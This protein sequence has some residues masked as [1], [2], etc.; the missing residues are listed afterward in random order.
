[1]K[2]QSTVYQQPDTAAIDSAND[3][4]I[5][6]TN[7]PFAY[8]EFEAAKVQAHDRML[9]NLIRLAAWEKL[10]Y[11]P[12]TM[13]S[14]ENIH[15]MP[16]WSSK[17]IAIWKLLGDKLDLFAPIEVADIELGSISQ[18]LAIWEKEGIEPKA[19]ARFKL[20]LNNSLTNEAMAICYRNQWNERLA[21][22]IGNTGFWQGLQHQDE[23][24]QNPALFFEQWGA[25]GHPFHPTTKAKLGI[26]S[27]QVFASSPEFKGSARLTL[28]AIKRSHATLSG[29]NEHEYLAMFSQYFPQNYI[30][31]Q[32]T[33]GALS[34]AYLPFPVHPQQLQA[35]WSQDL[36][37]GLFVP[38][39]PASIDSFSSLSFRTVYPVGGASK[40]F[41]KLPV[42]LQ[43]TSVQRTVSPR[44][45]YMGPRMSEL[46]TEIVKRDTLIAQVFS[47]LNE[48]IGLHLNTQSEIAKHYSVIFRA[49]LSEVLKP[50]EVA[51]PVA[52]LM[53]KTP[54]NKC[55]A[56]HVLTQD[57]LTIEA[58]LPNFRQYVA[59]LLNGVLAVYLKYGIALEAHQQNSFM[60]VADNKPA[61]FI[62][63]DFGGVRVHMESLQEKG[64]NLQLHQDRLIVE[65]L[66][67]KCLHKLIHSLFVCHLGTLVSALASD[68]SSPSKWFWQIVANESENVFE[69]CKLVMDKTDFQLDRKTLLNDSWPTK[70][71]LSMRV[72]QSSEDLWARIPNPLS[73]FIK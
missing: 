69:S 23:F 19:L 14:H 8:D 26:S 50:D 7:L 28:A 34:D 4:D 70:A 41:I 68:F 37:E 73:S 1:M 12:I 48:K 45:C 29:V 33:M 63:R 51:I 30:A 25:V 21:L 56:S 44:A 11:Q 72:E 18:W 32:Q 60:V 52:A 54:L 47:P 24:K 62:I 36:P 43:M 10:P 58:L 57:A 16:M 5:N 39:K 67:Q 65:E 64:L 71:L 55:L 46:L 2:S 27:A 59:K 53:A 13:D 3:N 22:S 9:Q 49:P 35:R 6:F 31:W 17:K 61:R 38:D 20:E 40:P 66:R 15:S 42:A